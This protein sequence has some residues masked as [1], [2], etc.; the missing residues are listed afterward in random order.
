MRVDASGEA[1]I[2]RSTGRERFELPGPVCLQRPVLEL[3]NWEHHLVDVF[4]TEAEAAGGEEAAGGAEESQRRGG[5]GRRRPG[6]VV[7]AGVLERRRRLLGP[8]R[9]WPGG[10]CRAQWQGP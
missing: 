10:P 9:S 3:L 5:G 2:A 6:G 1:C 8:E 7:T 4:A